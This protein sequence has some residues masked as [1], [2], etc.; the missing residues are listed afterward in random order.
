M[1]RFSLGLLVLLLFITGCADPSPL[2]SNIEVAVNQMFGTE[3]G[4][5]DQVIVRQKEET[6][7]VFGAEEF[8]ELV[9]KAKESK[10]R[11]ESFD[12]TIILQTSEAMK[13]Y[14]KEQTKEVL[15]YDSNTKV[16]CSVKVCYDV[17]SAFHS[18]VIPN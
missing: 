6:L 11:A 5:M 18:E 15:T 7:A 1:I 2:R 12:Y 8:L 10:S 13:E 3:F 16:L 17:P 14:S 4:V 9:Q